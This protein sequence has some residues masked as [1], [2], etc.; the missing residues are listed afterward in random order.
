MSIVYESGLQHYADT[1]ESYDA[2]PVAASVLREVPAAW[3]DTRL[4][5]GGPDRFVAIAR[6]DGKR[7]FVG[8]L[9][10][11]PAR[12]IRVPL[13]FLGAAT[14]DARIVDDALA[15]TRQPVTAAT[16][17]RLRLAANGGAVVEL[18]P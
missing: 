6:R 18:A 10:A 12:T 2:H 4:I 11:G 7:W 1:P 9:G 3:D 16:T 15:E 13:R 14:Y 8:V 17:L 5:A